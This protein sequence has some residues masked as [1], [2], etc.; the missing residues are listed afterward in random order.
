MG[1]HC[2]IH[3]RVINKKDF[4]FIGATDSAAPCAILMNLGTVLTDL[5]DK[6]L[7][8]GGGYVSTLQVLL[9]YRNFDMKFILLTPIFD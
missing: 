3:L 7:E 6:R 2:F 9:K 5:L 8:A 1:I 4:E